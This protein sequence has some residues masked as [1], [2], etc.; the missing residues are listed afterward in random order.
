LSKKGEAKLKPGDIADLW[1]QRLQHHT[2]PH[3]TWAS[4]SKVPQ[5]SPTTSSDTS[6]FRVGKTVFPTSPEA[7]VLVA[8]RAASG[9][10]ATPPGASSHAPRNLGGELENANQHPDGSVGA[11]TGGEADAPCQDATGALAKLF[12]C[13]PDHDK[14][15]SIYFMLVLAQ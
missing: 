5:P 3:L 4:L 13:L 14:L 1:A 11:A 6:G 8:Q 15:Q 9:I 10:A 7:A 12:F 2:L